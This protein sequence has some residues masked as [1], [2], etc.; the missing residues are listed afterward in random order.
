MDFDK[1]EERMNKTLSVLE[2]N[3]SEIRAGRANPAILNKI[4]VDY[5]GVPTQ[6]RQMSQV[7]VQDG[8]TLVI[9]PYDKSI[10]KEI[11]K[12]IIKAEI[13][14]TP[15]SD[16]ICIRLNFPPL[17][18]ERRKEIVK[19]VKKLGEEAKV[20]IRNVRRDMTDD[21]KKIEKADNLPEDTVK[22][23]QDKIQKLTDKYTG[24]VD[25]AVSEKEKEVM[26]V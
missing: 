19:D 2:E 25:S 16:G 20:A 23:N 4:M 17:T 8:T 6:L 10:L 7:T 11:E 9:S 26:T 1:I 18:E 3:F 5:Y 12:A 24:I 21:L 22:D 15:N 13:G 14:I